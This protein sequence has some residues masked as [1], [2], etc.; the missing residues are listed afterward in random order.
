MPEANESTY[1]WLKVGMPLH[2]ALITCKQ[3]V[4]VIQFNSIYSKTDDRSPK[5][6]VCQ[7]T[8]IRLVL[9]NVFTILGNN[10]FTKVQY[11]L[12]VYT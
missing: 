8:K 2:K 6:L 5:G 4:L 7:T 11:P 1:M 10:I 9:H 12:H 3:I